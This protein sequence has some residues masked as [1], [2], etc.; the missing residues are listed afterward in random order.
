MSR[1]EPFALLWKILK[2]QRTKAIYTL[3][4]CTW[5]RPTQQTTTG[6]DRSD[7]IPGRTIHYQPSGCCIHAFVV[8][9]IHT[10]TLL[11]HCRRRVRRGL[12]G[13]ILNGRPSPNPPSH[14]HCTQTAQRRRRR[15]SLLPYDALYTASFTHAECFESY[16]LEVCFAEVF[17]ERR[18]H[19]FF[20]FKIHLLNLC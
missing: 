5:S 17:C 12:A 8:V 10:Q 7:R 16:V 9:H 13:R 3:S 1:K 14:R 2:L 19:R 11:G 18:L 15:R 20:N 4:I 6:Q